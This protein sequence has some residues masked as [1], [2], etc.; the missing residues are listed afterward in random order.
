MKNIVIG[1][2]ID[3]VVINLMD[4]WLFEYNCDYEDN[5]TRN[6]ILEWD[7]SK[8]VKSECGKKIYDYIENPAI[9]DYCEP[10]KDSY[11]GIQFLRT[12]GRVVFITNPTI[13]CAGRKY[14]WLKENGYID[15]MK[16]Y[17][18]AKDKSLINYDYLIDDNFN[19]INLSSKPNVL[20]TQTWNMQYYYPIRMRS[21][22][23]FIDKKKGK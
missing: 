19:N 11:E 3:D 22:R 2:D 5:L 6:N 13:G 8:F 12:L 21:W 17:I 1:V 18:E 10:V 23:E 15:D 7:V 9:Y 20:F 4:Q 14:V 16:D